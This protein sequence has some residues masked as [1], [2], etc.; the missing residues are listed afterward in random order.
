[1]TPQAVARKSGLITPRPLR[2]YHRLSATLIFWFIRLL[3]GTVR[4][5]WEDR[6][7]LFSSAERAPVIF[8]IWHNRLALALE[9]RRSYLQ[10]RHSPRPLAA[11]VSA[12]KD[13]GI[14]ARVLERFDTQPVRGST[15]R[16]GP[17]ALL[18]LTTWSKRGH[19]L[20]I[21]P[22]G[23][24]GPRYQVQPG[25]IALAQLT[26]RA[27]VPVAYSL[28]RKWILKS[29]DGFQIPMPFAVCRMV[30]DRPLHVPRD[31][32]PEEREVWRRK[33]EHSLIAITED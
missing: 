6:S 32:S 15:S 9:V 11:I 3:A 14:L 21:T 19:D 18:E 13:G 22:D 27:V 8:C 28:S 4:F 30:L 2:W 31:L 20:A 16:R 24:R 23:P 29:W 26:G 1:M 5:R 17:Q 12:S 7:G 10:Q 25:V 33:L